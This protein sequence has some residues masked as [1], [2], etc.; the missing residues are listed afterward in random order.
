[1]PPRWGAGA[2]SH[3][4]AQERGPPDPCSGRVQAR[5]RLKTRGPGAYWSAGLRTRMF[6]SAQA[7]A[8]LKTRG[9]GARWSARL[10][11]RTFVSVQARA[12]LKTR[13]PGAYWSAG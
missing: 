11:T 10:Q 9:P 6:V 7:R 5:A 2:T 4:P 1:M 12:L 3:A 13:G 8:R